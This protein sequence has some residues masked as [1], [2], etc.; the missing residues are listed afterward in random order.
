MA[1]AVV[2]GAILSAFIDVLF[3]RLASPELVNFI[4]G[5]KPDKLLQKMKSQLLVVKVVLADAEQ[6]QI[7]NSNVK[8][9]LDL[10]NDLVYQ[11]DDLLDEVSTKA[12]TQKEVSNSFSHLFK[13]KKIVNISKLEDIV[14]RL[15]DILKQKDS[16]DLKEIAVENN[17]QW[18]AQTTSLEG[19]YGMYGRDKDKEAIM[20]LVLEDNSD[21]E[22]VSVIPIVAWVGLTKLP[23]AMQNLV[24]LRHLEIGKSSIKEMPKRMGKLNQLQ[25]LDLY[26]VGKHKENSI[27]ELGGFPNLHGRF[28]I[29]KLENVTNGEEA[30][31]AG[32]LN[33]K[34]INTLDLRW[35]LCNDSNIDFEIELDV[36]GKLQPHQD[37]K[38]LRIKGYNGTRFPIW[39]DNLSYRY[40]KSLHLKNCNNCCMLPSL[41]QLPSLKHILISEMNSV[42]T[43]FIKNCKKLEN[44]AGERLPVSLVKLIIEECP[45]LQRRCHVKDRQVWPKICHVRGIKVD[46]RWI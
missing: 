11:A 16:L 41:G 39:M 29:K 20:K 36:L 19:R 4:R 31:G 8:E 28:T 25:K 18:N 23:S 3:D 24:N 32:I 13:R 34:Y 37:L 10:L 40:I 43:L 17:Q 30:L 26:I 7:T 38:S 42:Q 12:A 45:L 27:K 6:K 14:E 1:L 15:D 35:S 9:W 44:I 22:E 33:K 46:G 2:G 21:G 5:K